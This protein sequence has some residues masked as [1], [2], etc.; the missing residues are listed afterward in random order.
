[1]SDDIAVIVNSKIGLMRDNMHLEINKIESWLN[2][3]ITQSKSI[4]KKQR[5]EVCHSK[6]EP[7]NLEQHHIA[8]R[9]HD[10]RVITVCRKCHVELS[11]SQKTWDIRWLQNNQSEHV[12]NGFFFLGLHDVLIL[13]SKYTASDICY[14]LAIHFRQKISD[15]LQ[16]RQQEVVC[17]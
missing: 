3:I 11:Q 10:F 14:S 12:K 7:Y 8:G 15:L 4:P 6:E 5:C 13:C 16:V 17:A 1:M 9:K 2:E